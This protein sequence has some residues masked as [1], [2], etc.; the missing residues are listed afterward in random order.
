M[1]IPTSK[2]GGARFRGPTSSHEY[3]QNESQKY[4]ELMELYKVSHEIQT[5]LQ[6]AH[7][8]VVQEN[9]SLH[10]YVQLLEDRLA[11]I[12]AQLTHLGD[13]VFL[14]GRFS[15]TSFVSQMLVEKGIHD[16]AYRLVTLPKIQEIP[17]THVV[18]ETGDYFL[19]SE[20]NIQVG[21]R[22][23]KG[24]I[25]ENEWTNALN[26]DPTT[27]WRRTVTYD[28]PQDV[29][30]NGEEVVVEIELPLKLVNNLQVNTLVIDPYPERGV[31]VQNIELHYHN[32]WQTIPGFHQETVHA[33]DPLRYS[34]RQKWYF[35]HVPVQKIRITLVQPHSIQQEGKTIFTLGLQSLGVSL[36][37]FEP[38]GADVWIPFDMEGVYHLDDVELLFLNRASFSYASTMNHL[39]EGNIYTYDL[40][41]EEL[42]G[43]KTPIASGDWNSQFAKRL[44]VNVKLFPDPHN[45]VNPCLHAA[46]L[47][48]TKE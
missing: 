22:H 45:G 39:L 29:P 30:E 17:K 43:S 37:L 5:R 20:L 44:W 11:T 46:R 27:C 47:H 35:P 16:E 26:G 28:S 6:A 32:G 13:S 18:T 21:R 42:D 3:N 9:A 34:P 8:T 31:S 23:D 7:E 38:S 36:T 12:E 19:P 33:V 24:Y 25:E 48:Y 15:R 1:R 2:T 41:K 10:Q 14:N 4:L 40:Y